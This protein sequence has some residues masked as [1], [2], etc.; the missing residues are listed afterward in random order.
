AHAELQHLELRTGGLSAEN[1]RAIATARLP[2]LRHLDVWYGD[3][4]YNGDATIVEVRAL[5]ARTDL[6][7]L[8]ELGLMNAAFT[9]E[10]C[11]ALR[12]APLIAQ[13]EKLDLSKG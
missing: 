8:V 1:A 12:D 13:V 11:G 5:I 3:P 6:P 4:N 7:E 9:D 10:I 2:R